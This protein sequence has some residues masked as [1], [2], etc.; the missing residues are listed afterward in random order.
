MTECAD[1]ARNDITA[2]VYVWTAAEVGDGWCQSALLARSERGPPRCGHVRLWV[3]E[4]REVHSVADMTSCDNAHLARGAWPARSSS[5]SAKYCCTHSASG[6]SP[7]SEED[8]TYFTSQLSH[9]RSTFS[10]RP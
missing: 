6:A 1:G 9:S 5:T 7:P 10:T 2:V 4:V 3:A 8:I